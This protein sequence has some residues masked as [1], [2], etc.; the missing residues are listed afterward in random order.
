MEPYDSRLKAFK[1]FHAGNPQVWHR[2]RTM[3]DQL[4]SRGWSHYSHDTLI[5][6][7]RFQSDVQ[8]NGEPFKIANE[9]KAFYGRWYIVLRNCP[10][11]FTLRQ[12]EGEPDHEFEQYVKNEGPAS[13]DRGPSEGQP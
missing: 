6:V 5:S 11:F 9:M 4:R 10:G 3:A 2:F 8:T 12:M 7:I 1:A 13:H